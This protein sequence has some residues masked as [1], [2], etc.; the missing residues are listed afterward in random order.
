V[1]KRSRIRLA[2]KHV[3][4]DGKVHEGKGYAYIETY[5][6]LR[7][8]SNTVHFANTHHGEGTH[9]IERVRPE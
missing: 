3:M 1:N 9:W 5:N 2:W 6:R 8:L 7:Q 4:F